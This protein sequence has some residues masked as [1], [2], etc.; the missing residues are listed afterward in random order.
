MRVFLLLVVWRHEVSGK[1]VRVDL[2]VPQGEFCLGWRP[3]KAGEESGHVAREREFQ[4][5][6]RWIVR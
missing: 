1:S 4:K 5:G 6:P 3:V 2:L